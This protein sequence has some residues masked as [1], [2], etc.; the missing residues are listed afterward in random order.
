MAEGSAEAPMQLELPPK[1]GPF[2]SPR[3]YTIQTTC[4]IELH[5]NP[6]LRILVDFVTFGFILASEIWFHRK[7]SSSF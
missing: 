7:K 5:I 2:L 1:E 3:E 4:K 6:L